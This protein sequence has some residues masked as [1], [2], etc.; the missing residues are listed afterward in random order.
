MSSRNW[1]FI[2]PL[3]DLIKDDHNADRIAF[4]HSPDAGGYI[5]RFAKYRGRMIYQVDLGYLYWC[6]K[7]GKDPFFN[8]ACRRFLDGL[9]AFID[10]TTFDSTLFFGYTY[11]E[12]RVPF[13]KVYRGLRLGECHDKPYFEW[14]MKK[15]FLRQKFPFFFR[16][17]QHHFNNPNKQEKWRDVG[18]LLSASA[19]TDELNL[20]GSGDDEDEEGDDLD[21]PTP[22]DLEF[23]DDEGVDD[24]HA[25]EDEYSGSEDEHDT[26]SS[27]VATSTRA[28][29]EDEVDEEEQVLVSTPE[30]SRNQRCP[31][32]R[33]RKR[34]KLR[35]RS[36]SSAGF[37]SQVESDGSA[38]FEDSGTESN[39]SFA[40]RRQ[41]RAMT[42][43]TVLKAA[44]VRRRKRPRPLAPVSDDEKT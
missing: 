15:A 16:A 18:E 21:E 22:S 40:E 13:G 38:D 27:N 29:S 8:E 31:A 5:I 4:F 19:Y 32:V 12:V 42:R 44:P 43:Q 26:T 36:S 30:R 41:T 35:A 2:P 3:L 1:E 20:R 10:D 11:L 17:L 33:K 14:C 34:K 39:A 25:A 28:T 23:I 7:H 24:E 9:E 37:I 6:L